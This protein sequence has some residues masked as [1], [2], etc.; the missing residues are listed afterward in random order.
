LVAWLVTNPIEETAATWNGAREEGGEM[1]CGSRRYLIGQSR[2]WAVLGRTSAMGGIADGDGIK[3]L[4]G[5]F[6]HPRTHTFDPLLPVEPPEVQGRVSERNG[7][8]VPSIEDKSSATP[9]IR[10]FRGSAILNDRYKKIER[11]LTLVC[12]VSRSGR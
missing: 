6:L 8:S 2:H 4:D 5:S 7:H 11:A 9:V 3:Q 1:M 12:V 10:A